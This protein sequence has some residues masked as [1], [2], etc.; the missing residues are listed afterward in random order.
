MIAVTRLDGEEIVINAELIE[1]IES[2]PETVIVLVTRKRLLVREPV[3]EI[4]RRVLAYR[5]A[6]LGGIAG[7]ALLP[8]STSPPVVE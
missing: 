1:T 3:D 5:Q 7:S 2:V 6:V 8:R 4:V